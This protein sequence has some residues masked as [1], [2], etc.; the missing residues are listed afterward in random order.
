MKVT[1]ITIEDLQNMG[2]REGLVLQGCGGNPND[3]I[4]GINDIF[5][6]EGILEKG[7]KF[8]TAFRIPVWAADMPAFPFRGCK[9]ES[10]K[11]GSME[12]GHL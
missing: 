6:Q 9:I 4:N 2:K 11:A 10:G 8:E 5:T 1:T 3:W 12:P 7:T